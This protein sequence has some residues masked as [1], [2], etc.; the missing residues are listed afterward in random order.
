MKHKRLL[1]SVLVGG[2]FLLAPTAVSANR[3]QGVDLARYQGYTAQFGRADDEFAICQ[4][5]GYQG[6]LY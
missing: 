1:A 2:A 6:G 3:P 5:G 4:I